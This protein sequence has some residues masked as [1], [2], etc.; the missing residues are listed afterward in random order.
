MIQLLKAYLPLFAL[1]LCISFWSCQG[2]VAIAKEEPAIK[3]N[4]IFIM[5]DDLGYADVGC[6]GQKVIQTPHIDALAKSGIQFSQCYAGSPVCA[7]SRSV[8]MTGLHTGHTTVRGNFGKG[9][10]TG[11]GGG[12]G[13]IPLAKEDI[14]IA[15]LLSEEGY[16]TAMI[17]KWGLGEPGTTGLPNDQGFDYFYGFL[18]QRRAHTYYP[19][20][21]WRNK[22]KVDLPANHEERHGQYIHD[23]FMEE[24]ISFIEQMDD[25]PFFLYLP[26]TLP[27]DDYEIDDL[28]KYVDSIDWTYEE[29]VYAAMVERLD[30]SVGLISTA[31]KEHG[32][33][34]NTM[35]IFTSDNGA[36]RRWEGRFNSSGSLRG[37]KRDLYEGGLRV[38]LIISYPL[39]ISSDRM[40]DYPLS[41]ADFLPTLAS[42][43]GAESPDVDGIDISEI[44]FNDN[45]ELSDDRRFYWEFYEGGYQQAVRI[46]LWKAMLGV[47]AKE[48]ELYDLTQDPT[49]QNN[50]ASQHPDIVQEISEY[51]EQEHVESPYYSTE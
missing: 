2:R 17:G 39:Q 9:G 1:F 22:E 37:R 38:P 47:N 10:V 43:G 4:I 7:P 18:N 16:Q 46:G 8:L 29:R 34:D 11:L 44:F 3:P 36:A 6:Y 20:Y 40:S 14:T 24:T 31:L 21:I 48:W 32:I 42:V 23:L 30:V 50:I 15:E 5:A 45:P 49:E 27:H 28:G 51:A 13:R 33:F 25:E 12:E 19:E 35:I 26:Y 41:F